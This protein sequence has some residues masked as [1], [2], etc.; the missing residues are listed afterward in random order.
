MRKSSPT[1]RTYQGIYQRFASWLA[2]R[3]DVAEASIDA[4]T[5]ETLV[6]DSERLE[7]RSLL[8]MPAD[9]AANWVP[10]R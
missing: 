3:D 5:S 6:L 1:Q 9:R 10:R 7:A 2:G 8:C 4:F